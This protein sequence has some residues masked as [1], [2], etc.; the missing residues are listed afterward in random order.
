MDLEEIEVLNSIFE[1]KK[2]FEMI[3]NLSGI[4]NVHLEKSSYPNTFLQF[5]PPFEVYFTVPIKKDASSK[6]CSIKCL[7]PDISP[8]NLTIKCNTLK[9]QEIEQFKAE[10]L[11]IFTPG[12]PMLYDIYNYIKEVDLVSKFSLTPERLKNFETKQLFLNYNEIRLLDEFNS[13]E[14]TCMVCFSVFLGVNCVYNTACDEHVF[15]KVCVEGY[16]KSKIEERELSIESPIPKCMIPNCTGKTVHSVAKIQDLVGNE[17]FATYNQILTENYI[18]KDLN[19]Y[20]CPRITCA[21]PII[22]PDKSDIFSIQCSSCPFVYCGHCNFAA[23]NPPCKI[24]KTVLDEILKAYN[25]NDVKKLEKYKI[26]YTYPKLISLIQEAKSIELISETTK[27]CP[28]CKASTTKISGC[29]KMHCRKCNANW[30]W[31]CE[32]FLPKEDPYLHYN[33]KTSTNK[34]CYD[35]L[36]EGVIDS[37]GDED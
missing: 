30:C 2:I 5:L 9:K 7:Y 17:M 36:F 26:K 16:L 8:L 23:H 15:C 14:F 31:L 4:L 20:Y 6:T 35:S 22:V 32:K 21:A 33:V 10:L 37:E 12:D 27:A 28:S 1:S 13:K 34:R 24:T 11:N 18:C 3:D 29:N 19:M 25:E